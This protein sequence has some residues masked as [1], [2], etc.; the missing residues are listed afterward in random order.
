MR[1]PR[2]LLPSSVV[3]FVHNVNTTIEAI[4]Q[5]SHGYLSIDYFTYHHLEMHCGNH[6]GSNYNVLIVIPSLQ[7]I[8]LCPY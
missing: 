8:T 3:M 5:I 7:A 2:V 6:M 1:K 4:G